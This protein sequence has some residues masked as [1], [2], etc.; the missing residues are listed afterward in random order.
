ML[1]ICGH[2]G[3]EM[4]AWVTQGTHI[5]GNKVGSQGRVRAGLGDGRVGGRANSRNLYKRSPVEWDKVKG[6]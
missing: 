3:G 1:I 4:A 2:M 6:D 5:S